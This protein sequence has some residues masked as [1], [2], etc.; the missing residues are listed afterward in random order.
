MNAKQ[1][2]VRLL[3]LAVMIVMVLLPP[4]RAS[5]TEGDNNTPESA[6]L[7]YRPLWFR[8]EVEED[9]PRTGLAQRIDIV[10]LALQLGAVL[11]L[12]NV[13]L[14]LLKNRS[15]RRPPEQGHSRR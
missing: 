8:L 12:T 11:V 4:W 15:M 7:G 5:Y 13:G 10:R 6:W 9:D 2:I 14:V 1:K 3:G